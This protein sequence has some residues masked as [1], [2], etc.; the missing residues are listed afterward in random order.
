MR[1]S[2]EE[3]VEEVNSHSNVYSQKTA[4]APWAEKTH[5]CQPD[6]SRVAD[7]YYGAKTTNLDFIDAHDEFR[8]VIN[9]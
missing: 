9:H 3:I 2:F 1:S 7:K 5:P 8:F 4:K 6:Y